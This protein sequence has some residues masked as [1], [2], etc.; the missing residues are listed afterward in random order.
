MNPKRKLALEDCPSLKITRGVLS[1]PLPPGVEL[2][3]VRSNLPATGRA[4]FV[5]LLVCPN[6]ERAC[7]ALYR[8]VPTLPWAC[9]LCRF[10]LVDYAS[11]SLSNSARAIRRMD[12]LH[13]L[14]LRMRLRGRVGS[15][16]R[17]KLL[18][19]LF[20]AEARLLRL[21]R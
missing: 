3:R 20:T 9:R 17:G 1:A 8:P 2:T 19:Q 18:V 15:A 14:R 21:G 10:H 7:R 11:Q 5:W 12:E 13:E 16:A 6:C 4:Y